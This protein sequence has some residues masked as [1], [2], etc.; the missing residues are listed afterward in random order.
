MSGKIRNLKIFINA[1]IQSELNWLADTI[2]KAIG[3]RFV[4]DG[5]WA[6]SSADLTIWTDASLTTAFAFVYGH[7]GFVYQIHPPP[8]NIKVDIFFL[9]LIAIFSAI[10]HAATNLSKPPCR[11]LRLTNSLDSLGVLNSLSATQSLHNSVLLRIAEVILRSHIDLRVRHIKGK[12]NIKADLLSHL[13]LDDFAC[14]FP[15]TRIRLFDPPCDLLP[16]QWRLCF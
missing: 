7:E 6:D 5:F 12:L 15:D 9:E 13:L 14:Q 16:A 1:T 2:P 4:D 11:L 8:S 10:Y 3:V